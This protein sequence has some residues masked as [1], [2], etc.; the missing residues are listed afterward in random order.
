MLYEIIKAR[1]RYGLMGY[2]PHSEPNK[3]NS[4]GITTFVALKSV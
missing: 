4:G 2:Q 3:V 1:Q